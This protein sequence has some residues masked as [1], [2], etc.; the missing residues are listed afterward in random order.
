MGT[1]TVNIQRFFLILTTVV[2]R[3]TAFFTH[4]NSLHRARFA[5]IDEMSHLL[6]TQPMGDGLLL[7]VGHSHFLIV[8]PQKTRSE[9]GNLLIVAPT[10]SGK[11]LLPT[12]KLL[13][14]QGS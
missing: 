9:L 8:K 14:W 4:Q 10:R 5:R 7:G 3:I 12:S 1:W 6:A 11:E 13:T 2:N